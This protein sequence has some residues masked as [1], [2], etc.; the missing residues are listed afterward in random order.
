[1]IDEPARAELGVAASTASNP[2]Q[3]R[4]PAAP[5]G[6]SIEIADPK[7][8][9][10]DRVAKPAGYRPVFL[11]RDCRVALRSEPLQEGFAMRPR[12]SLVIGLFMSR[13]PFFRGEGQD[14]WPK[15]DV[16]SSASDDLAPRQPADRDC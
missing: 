12:P 3:H 14:H 13:I 7:A 2:A 5:S 10:L 9:F 1:M 16:I 11:D 6:R 4:V 15:K 8:A